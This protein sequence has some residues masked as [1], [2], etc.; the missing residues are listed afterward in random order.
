MDDS[1]TQ[2]R[3]KLT[4]FQTWGSGNHHWKKMFTRHDE[5]WAKLYPY[6][7]YQQKSYFQRPQVLSS[8]DDRLSWCPA[9]SNIWG[10][11][12]PSYYPMKST[13]QWGIEHFDGSLLLLRLV[14]S[15]PRIWK[16]RDLIL[17]VLPPRTSQSTSGSRTF[18]K[19]VTIT[20]NCTEFIWVWTCKREPC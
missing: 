3:T 5:K 16:S 2:W 4:S 18:I 14:E 10:W 11:G 20:K 19:T 15:T 7:G 17:T 9:S 6:L 8:T 12:D 1:S 13:T